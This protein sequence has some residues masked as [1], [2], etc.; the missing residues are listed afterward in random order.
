VVR[1]VETQGVYLAPEERTPESIAAKFAE[2]SDIKTA[3]ILEGA[4]QQ[5][6]K[7]V[8]MAAKAAGID[9]SKK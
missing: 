5:T 3:Q 8:A 2:I 6:Q 9:L 1:V 4:F 7:Y